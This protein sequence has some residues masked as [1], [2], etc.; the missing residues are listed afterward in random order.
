MLD[1]WLISTCEK[2]LKEENTE[3]I[4]K[5]DKLLTTNQFALTELYRQISVQCVERG[6]MMRKVMDNYIDLTIKY[7]T[8]IILG[9]TEY[10]KRGSPKSFKKV[11]KKKSF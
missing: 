1:C 2:I 5:I 3:K 7:Y 10:L 8:L 4:D 9:K 11:S 6:D